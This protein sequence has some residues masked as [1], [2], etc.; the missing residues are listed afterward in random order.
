M[1]CWAVGVVT[2]VCM[3][4]GLCVLGLYIHARC[5]ETDGLFGMCTRRTCTVH[6][7]VWCVAVVVPLI[8]TLCNCADKICA[9]YRSKRGSPIPLSEEEVPLTE[10]CADDK[11]DEAVDAAEEE[12]NGVER[13]EKWMLVKDRR[14]KRVDESDAIPKRCAGKPKTWFTATVVVLL[15]IYFCWTILSRRCGWVIYVTP[16]LTAVRI[17]SL[18]AGTCITSVKRAV[19]AEHVRNDID[20]ALEAR[21]KQSGQDLGSCV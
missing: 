15:S 8:Y 17:L 4:V 18:A 20:E 11:D 3:C 5:I 6:L 12:E 2:R 9:W 19:T 10:A 1:I 14:L 7:I 16:I 13:G 21:S